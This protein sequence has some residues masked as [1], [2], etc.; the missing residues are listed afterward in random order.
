MSQDMSSPL[1]SSLADSDPRPASAGSST[2]AFLV[3]SPNTLKDNLDPNAENKNAPRQKRR[4]TRYAIITSFRSRIWPHQSRLWTRSRLSA[5]TTSQ[6]LLVLTPIPTISPEDQKVLE[7]EFARNPKP[8]KPSR[9][10]IIKKV[11]LG[12]KEIQVR[13]TT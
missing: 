1:S 13:G 7:E 9:L 11:A 8:D 10:E 5:C 2:T 4:R 3:Y 12:E 6:T